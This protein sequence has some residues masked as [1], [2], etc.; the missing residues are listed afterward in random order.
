M[1]AD[2]FIVPTKQQ[3]YQHAMIHIYIVTSQ[4]V[5]NL[6]IQKTI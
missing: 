3:D 1:F 2:N 5:T 6:I 4:Q